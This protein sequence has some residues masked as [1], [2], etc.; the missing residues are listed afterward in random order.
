MGAAIGDILGLAAGVAVSPLPIVAIILVLATPT[1]RLNGTLFAVGWL[2]GLAVLGTVVLLLAQP[3][4]ASSGGEPA[5]WTG[6]LKLLLGVLLLAAAARQWRGRPA[7]GAEPEMPKWMAGL[8]RIRPG[9]ALGLG[10]LL[11][12]VNPKNGGLTIAAA[13]SIAAAGLSGGEEAAALAVFVLIGSVGVLAPLVLYL[14]AGEAAARTLDGWKTWAVDH[15]AAV[16]AVLLLV[17]GVKL[18]GDGIAVVF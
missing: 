14:T 3:A 11:S 9:G 6:W 7:P 8:D 12:S 18:V 4:D 1:G 2:V 10:A 15:N 13:A 5:A 16:M 17:F